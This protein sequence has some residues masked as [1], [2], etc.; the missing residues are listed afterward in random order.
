VFKAGSQPDTGGHAASC[1]SMVKLEQKL[2]YFA[3]EEPACFSSAPSFTSQ[4]THTG[5]AAKIFPIGCF[6][7]ESCS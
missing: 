1:T 4:H 2:D 3:Q 5:L 7:P 6:I